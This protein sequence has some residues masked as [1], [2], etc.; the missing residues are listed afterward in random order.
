MQSTCL[1]LAL[2]RSIQCM[3]LSDLAIRSWQ[4]ANPTPPMPKGTIAKTAV[5]QCLRL[6]CILLPVRGRRWRSASLLVGCVAFRS[7]DGSIGRRQRRDRNLKRARR[8]TAGCRTWIKL[9]H[10]SRTRRTSYK[11]QT[12]LLVQHSS[13][14]PE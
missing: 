13:P 1:L 6:S 10:S 7:S 4:V 3:E 2:T 12:R 9:V 8:G 14:R 11:Q 5:K